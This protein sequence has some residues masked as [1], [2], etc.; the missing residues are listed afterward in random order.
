M[1]SFLYFR[2]HIRIYD[3]LIGVLLALL[4]FS[5]GTAVQAATIRVETGCTLAQ[6]FSAALTNTVP[7]GS[8]CT[9]GDASG[10]TDED[11]IVLTADITVSSEIAINSP[12][13]RTNE[14]RHKVRLE[15]NGRAISNSGNSKVLNGGTD[16]ELTVNDT[17][18][19]GGGL[20]NS[21]ISYFSG[22]IFIRSSVFED[23]GDSVIAV[24]QATN[25]TIVDSIF[26]D[27]SG[28][29]G[30]A[31][32]SAGAVRLVVRRSLFE[33]NSAPNVGGAI[34]SEGGNTID[35]ESSRFINNSAASHG[36]AIWTTSGL[37]VRK[38]TFVGN[39]A[40]GQGGAIWMNNF[41]N[42]SNSTFSG[43]SADSGAIAVIGSGCDS[44]T[45]IRMDH[46]TAVG[47]T[48]TNASSGIL[49]RIICT[50]S[51]VQKL[52]IRNSVFAG[53]SGRDCHGYPT[54]ELDPGIWE[55]FLL[56]DSSYIED[57]S[58]LASINLE[59]VGPALLG[60][61]RTSGGGQ[62]YFTPM[63]GSPLIDAGAAEFCWAADQ[64]GRGRSVGASCD[65]G[66]IEV[67]PPRESRSSG[68][69]D[70]ARSTYAPP[71]RSTCET[72]LPLTIT[73]SDIA[74]GMQCQVVGDSGV[75]N[76]QVVDAGYLGAVDIWGYIAGG[77]DVCFDQRGEFVFLDAATSP[78]A[79][80]ALSGYSGNGGSCV[81]LDR[82]GTLVLLPSDSPL[83]PG[84][85][86]WST[87]NEPAT[88]LSGCALTT[89]YLLNIRSSPGFGD[90]VI[91]LAASGAR[92]LADA[93]T[94][95]WYR[96]T[97]ENITGWISADYVTSA[98]ACG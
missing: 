72:G 36:G 89:T 26:R 44:D 53:N 39:S 25:I 58:C 67:Q 88:P 1:R 22:D 94:P 7:S 21:A 48:V 12:G 28:P 11:V 95:R 42:V 86:V 40:N 4:F 41:M 61:Q 78:R 83:L 68:G 38:S 35:V 82:L 79:L 73:L 46:V 16:L 14:I 59:S 77:V 33:S 23:F 51:S 84:L 5:S 30:G 81:R 37:D 85:G 63:S 47:N 2:F 96:V 70:E 93:R 62:V 13:S 57:G 45:V 43:N 15:G 32:F 34:S 8:S 64:L 54:N 80:S 52:D 49:D 60:P 17:V 69:A 20:T 76:Q 92:L 50:A 55:P 31:I 6:A 56:L 98:G 19:R 3:G 29:E 91:G 74:D 65:L 24:S 97:V 10:A 66:S 18:F 75:G 71:A 9:A 27:N 90:N 87:G